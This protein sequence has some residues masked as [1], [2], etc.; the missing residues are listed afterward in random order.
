MMGWEICTINTT[1]N[2]LKESRNI[3]GQIKTNQ[4]RKIKQQKKDELLNNRYPDSD[5]NFYLIAGY[6][7]GET[8][9]RITWEETEKEDLLDDKE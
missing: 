4:K 8:P 6:T 1:P 9:Y 5:K 3:Y 7:S 2:S